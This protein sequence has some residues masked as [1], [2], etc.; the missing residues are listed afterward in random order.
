MTSAIE[1][2]QLAGIAVWIFSVGSFLLISPLWVWA[3]LTDGPESSQLDYVAS[4]MCGISY[5]P[6]NGTLQ[7][8]SFGKRVFIKPDQIGAVRKCYQLEYGPK[9]GIVVPTIDG[10]KEYS[11]VF[12]RKRDAERAY[13]IIEKAKQQQIQSG[14]QITGKGLDQNL[15][16]TGNHIVAA[17]DKEL[18]ILVSAFKRLFD[19][20][21]LRK[22]KIGQKKI[23][24]YIA[25]FRDDSQ[26]SS[27][28][29]WSEIPNKDIAEALHKLIGKPKGD[30]KK[31]GY[32]LDSLTKHVSYVR[33]GKFDGIVI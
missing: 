31:F 7:V 22:R 28:R 4:L 17:K 30:P 13:E 10:E 24:Q 6:Q 9:N 19:K 23:W 18:A 33:T 25:H 1:I 26:M 12:F 15:L 8:I 16:K 14:K 11:L 29:K 2:V 27:R 21:D 5:N 32:E 20:A 3:N